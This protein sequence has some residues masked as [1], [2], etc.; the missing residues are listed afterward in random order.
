MVIKE[1]TARVDCAM[2]E[3]GKGD[4]E[5]KRGAG[6]RGAGPREQI[7]TW[8]GYVGV[9]AAGREGQPLDCKRFRVGL[10]QECWEE[11]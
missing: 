9:R 5:R 1:R 7:P 8:L 10:G 4:A 11:P 6:R 3:E 2:R